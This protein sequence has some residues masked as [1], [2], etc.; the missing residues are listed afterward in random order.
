MISV[1][2]LGNKK[3]L[4]VKAYYVFCSVTNYLPT[5]KSYMT[6]KILFQKGFG[7]SNGFVRR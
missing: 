4:R 6:E 2:D 1:K 7:D 3:Q 5:A